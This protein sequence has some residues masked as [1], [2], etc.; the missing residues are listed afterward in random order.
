MK[1]FVKKSFFFSEKFRINLKPN[2]FPLTQKNPSKKFKLKKTSNLC[3]KFDLMSCLARRSNTPSLIHSF[4]DAICCALEWNN[5]ER[6]F[7]HTKT[8]T[9]THPNVKVMQF[10]RAKPRVQLRRQ[11]FQARLT[12]PRVKQWVLQQVHS[13]V[14][15]FPEVL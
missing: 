9:R 13:R 4:V 10:W 1:I 5:V 3:T 12:G 2:I 8:H 7:A 15:F 14:F 11:I 6:S